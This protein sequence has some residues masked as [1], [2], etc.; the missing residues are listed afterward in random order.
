MDSDFKDFGDELTNLLNNIDLDQNFDNIVKSLAS[1]RIVKEFITVKIVGMDTDGKHWFIYVEFSNKNRSTSGYFYCS[2][3]NNQV[4][5]AEEM[6][7]K[8][9]EFFTNC[10]SY[11]D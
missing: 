4:I 5:L 2:Y 6:Y 11:L 7:D 9:Y 10:M 8:N 3:I 1:K